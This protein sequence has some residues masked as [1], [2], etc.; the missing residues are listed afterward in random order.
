MAF[1]RFGHR[2]SVLPGV[3]LNIGLRGLSVNVGPPGANVTFGRHGAT[4]TLGLPGS[5]ISVHLPLS[6][7]DGGSPARPLAPGAP[8]PVTP[9]AAL[10]RLQPIKSAAID[11]LGSANLAELREYLQAVQTQSGAALDA[12]EKAKG[13]LSTVNDGHAKLLAIHGE[14]K[15]RL[16]KLEKSWLRA[17]RKRSLAKLQGRTAAHPAEAKKA[18]TLQATAQNRLAEAE[19]AYEALFLDVDFG[20][21]GEA[22]KLWHAVELAF[23]RLSQCAAIWDLT[24]SLRKRKG[25]GRSATDETVDRKNVSLSVE[26]LD[27]IQTRY[28]P[29]RW[30]NANGDDLLLYPG[31]LVAYRDQREF[32]LID[33]K[34]LVWRSSR[35]LFHEQESIPS[36]S[37]Q[38]D[39]TWTFANKDGSRDR[40]YAD[41]DPIPVM[42]YGRLDLTTA[43]GLHEAYMFSNTDPV[44]GFIAALSA[45]EAV[46]QK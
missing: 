13:T 8:V 31:M 35:V 20:L 4:A 44:S 29:L 27:V 15:V 46:T 30:Q 38:V 41:N 1:V 18:T 36:D 5:G 7:A 33:M 43:S 11:K 17:L 16:A 14:E 10:T 23:L 22:H 21:D 26:A 9:L 19:A 3:H 45:F 39:T 37:K 34:D 32:S 2:I 24:G 12:I 42:E 25:E 28:V 6:Q 40:R